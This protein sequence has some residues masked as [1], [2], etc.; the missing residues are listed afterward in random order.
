MNKSNQL[1]ILPYFIKKKGTNYTS[2][3][4]GNNHHFLSNTLWGE[5][6][7]NEKEPHKEL[8][9]VNIKWESSVYCMD[10]NYC[11]LEGLFTSVKIIDL[12]LK[13]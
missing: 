7:A 13:P 2:Q 12:P 8:I 10:V 9:F 5:R 3:A 4:Q 1:L 11:I 6:C